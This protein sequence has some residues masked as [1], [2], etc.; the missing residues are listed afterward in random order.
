[1]LVPRTSSTT[2]GWRTAPEMVARSVPGSSMVP[3]A[4]NQAGPHW[5]IWARWAAVSTLITSVGRPPT[6][7]SNTRGGC[8][9]LGLAAVEEVD[10]RALL[11]GHEAGGHG[12]DAQTHGR[13]AGT[14][15]VDERAFDSADRGVV[16]SVEA[17]DHAVRTGRARRG[18]C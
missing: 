4:R 11:A 16:G 18:Q 13:F 9:G 10:E 8:G 1:M 6:P 2:P 12:G 17:D 7:R 3:H 15:S 14:C 5:M